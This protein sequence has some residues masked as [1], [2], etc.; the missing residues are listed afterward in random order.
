ML[1]LHC[2]TTYSDGTLSPAQLVNRAV[3]K[4]VKALAITDHDTVAGWADAIASAQ[5]HNLEIVPGIELSTTYNERSMHI[6]GFY[7]DEQSLVAPLQERVN[8]RKRRAHKMAA[9][10]AELG[11]PIELPDMSGAMA[12]GRP[13]IAQ[14]LLQAGHVT[15]KEDAFQRFL[16]DDGP[17]YVPYEKFTAQEGIALLLSCGAVPVWAHPYLFRGGT[18]ET[19]LPELVA[20]GLM[21]VEVYHPNHSP[22]DQRK[23]EELCQQYDL[24]IT[25][26]SDY[27]GPSPNSKKAED[28]DLNSLQVPLDLLTPIKMAAN[29]LKVTKS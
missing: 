11:Y 27:H 16:R 23:L 8:G 6:L 20:A 4:G 10:L 1:E 26:G 9:K 18:V 7:P 21:G 15:S 5:S 3:A 19:V 29:Q 24:M 22:S 13:H 12:P 14:A 2:H 25:G 28:H 17:A